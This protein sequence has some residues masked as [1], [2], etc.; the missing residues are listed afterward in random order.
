VPALIET[1]SAAAGRGR[2]GSLSKQDHA[3][4]P[5]TVSNLGMYGVDSF[6]AIIDPD[7]NAILAVGS[8]R[9]R[10]VPLDGKYAIGVAPRLTVNLRCD[11]RCVDGV[12]AAQF[13]RTLASFFETDPA[14]PASR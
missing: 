7:Q 1:V 12:Q 5:I 8:V 11:H 2:A 14:G 4:A 13:L 3:P 6:D 9:D 10:V